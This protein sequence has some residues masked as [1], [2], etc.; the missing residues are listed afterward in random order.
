MAPRYSTIRRAAYEPAAGEDGLTVGFHTLE[1]PEQIATRVLDLCN[2]TRNERNRFRVPPTRRLDEL[3][4]ALDLR[5]GVL[6]RSIA[7]DAGP[8][9]WLYCP[10]DAPGEPLPVPILLRLLDF[11]IEELR[12]EPEHAKAVAEV[13]D[14]LREHAPIWRYQEVPLLRCSLSAGGTAQPTTLQYLLAAQYFARRIQTLTPCH[15]DGLELHFRPVSRRVVNEA[16]LM[17]Q[18]LTWDDEDRRRWW[19]SVVVGVTMHTVP[20]HPRPWLHVRVGVRRWATNPEPSTGLLRLG[21]RRGSAVYLRPLAPWLPGVP[22]SDRYSVAHVVKRGDDHVWRP[23]DPASLMA[24]L[25]LAARPFPDPAS[26]L[27]EPHRW[28]PGDQGVERGVDAL[29]VHN[30]H[31][32]EHGVGAGF[33]PDERSRLVGS[34]ERAL[35]ADLVRAPD[36]RRSSLR[37]AKPVNARKVGSSERTEAT[38]VTLQNTRRASLAS[39]YTDWSG[40]AE[41]TAR[42]LWRSVP[43]RDAVIEALVT[44]L[45][46]DGDGGASEVGEQAHD[47]SGRGEPVVL[48]W[49][50]PEL[51]VTLHCLRMDNGLADNLGVA[52]EPAKGRA[53]RGAKAVHK[54]RADMSEF[55]AKDGANAAVP[56]VAIVEIQGRSFYRS[57]NDPKFALRLGAA[58]SGVVTQFIVTPTPKAMRELP[59]AAM[60]SWVDAIRQLGGTVVPLTDVPPSVPAETQYLAVWTA[61]KARGSTAKS[62]KGKLPVAVLVR[63]WLDGPGG[64]MGWDATAMGGMGAWTAYP[65]FLS[66][67]PSLAAVSDHDLADAGTVDAPWFDWSRNQDEQRAAT[68]EFLQQVLHSEQVRGK[69]TVL[70]VDAQN[71]RWLWTWMQDGQVEPDLIRTGIAA[72][73]RLYPWLRLVRLR[74][75]ESDETPQWWGLA[76]SGDGRG[77]PAGLWE[78]DDEDSRIFYSTM[79]KGGTGRTSAVNARKLGVRSLAKGKRM[80]E[81][82]TDVDKPARNPD[83]LEIAVLGC[84]PEA[85]DDPRA[86]AMAVHQL[87]QAPDYRDALHRPLPLHLA[88]KAQE[89][90]LPMRKPSEE[91]APDPESP[92]ELAGD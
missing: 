15:F 68:E 49:R 5:L 13:C 1:F 10:V 35:M 11:W 88:R 39:L 55:L 54:R 4:Q 19:F 77:L 21:F 87:R 61:T 14:A 30:T 12:P 6:P 27:S 81:W 9:P 34:F 83:L 74:T 46:L 64:V 3:L 50:Q 89:Y 2:L 31:M 38:K 53:E 36:L 57:M 72:A 17:S 70:L 47:R 69:P 20:F 7:P 28:F 80:G 44:V 85:G 26:L 75:R 84:H 73:R 59:D 22:A 33:M 62:A 82:T 43:T 66:R 79:P 51:T 16:E 25:A 42:L 90:I 8:R 18:P 76:D 37:P 56:S 63:P 29:V 24:R 45:G 52:Y 86:L 92:D 41:F 60:S 48:R 40:T 67:L 23:G 65:R 78:N 32:G 71:I 91:D 58:D